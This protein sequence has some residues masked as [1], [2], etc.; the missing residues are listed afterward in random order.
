MSIQIFNLFNSQQYN[1]INSKEVTYQQQN[2]LCCL[3][4]VCLLCIT[5]TIK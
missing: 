5:H 2:D 4:A 3:F 1:L